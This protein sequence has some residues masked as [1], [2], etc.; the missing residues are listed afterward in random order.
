MEDPRDIRDG[1][2]RAIGI[3]AFGLGIPHLTG[4]LEP[5]GP[6]DARYWLGLGYFTLLSAALW[7]GNRWLLFKQREH[8]DWFDRPISKI[9]VLLFAIICFSTPLS[10]VG[11]SAWYGLSGL[12]AIQWEL[13]QTATLMIVICVVFVTHIY[14]TV[15][16]IKAR[17]SDLLRLTRLERSRAEAELQA[18]KNQIDPHFMFNSL[19]TLSY[20]IDTEPTRAR[21]FNEHLALVYRYILRNRDR[22]LVHLREE[23][24]FVRNYFA[25]LELRFGGALRLEVRLEEALLERRLLPP[26]SL[27]V[28]LE[29][30]VKH[31]AFSDDAPLSILVTATQDSIVVQNERRPREL[32]RPSS[33]VGLQNLGDRYRLLTERDITI[34][35]DPR[36]FTV[37]LPTLEAAA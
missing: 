20:L 15:F 10:I 31:N 9:A 17:E 12:G 32:A 21:E 37:S 7:H 11:L 36:Q 18:L 23:L 2:T 26:I 30:A 13:V 14:E 8:L 6:G 33:R 27:Q 5:L 28:L 25:L 3:P 34:T 29:N 24:D 16:L 4:L 35:S 22:R 1:W 19:N